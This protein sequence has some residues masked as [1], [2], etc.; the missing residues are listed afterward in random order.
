MNP[1]LLEELK[2]LQPMCQDACAVSLLMC[3]LLLVAYCVFNTDWK[4][5][6]K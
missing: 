2:D 1:E 5:G 6:K 3:A 4:G